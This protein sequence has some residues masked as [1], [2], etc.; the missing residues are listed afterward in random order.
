[1]VI[2]ARGKEVMRIPLNDNREINAEGVLGITR[3]EIKDK[4][5]RIIESPCKNKICVETGWIQK[6]H[7]HVICA[8]NQVVIRLEGGR[9]KEK[10]DGITE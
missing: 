5:A 6:S 10:I 3:I 1:M 8:P 4:Q 9:N 2:Q 7:Q